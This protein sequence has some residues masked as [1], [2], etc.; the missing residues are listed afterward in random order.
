VTRIHYIADSDAMWGEHE[1]DY[2]FLIQKPNIQALLDKVNPNE[3]GEVLFVDPPQLKAMLR[4][5]ELYRGVALSPEEAAEEAAEAAR[6]EAAGEE[7]GS[8]VRGVLH[9]TPWARA[10]ME[11]FLF[12]W[13]E[14]V[15]PGKDLSKH[16]DRARIH[17]LGRL[18][19]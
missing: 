6:A 18:D 16:F 8:A 2:L 13:W 7:G 17:R 1:V 19:P 15:G 12:L 4:R 11:R 10:I 3:V 5:A 9:F 14:D